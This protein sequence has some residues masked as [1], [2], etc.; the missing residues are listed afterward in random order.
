MGMER[1]VQEIEQP[2]KEHAC[3]MDMNKGVGVAGGSG[4]CGVEGAKGENWG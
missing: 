4:E 1:T 2:K 3:P